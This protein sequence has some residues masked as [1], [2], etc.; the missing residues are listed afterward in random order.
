[1][2]FYS[3]FQYIFFRFLSVLRREDRE[4]MPTVINRVYKGKT[5]CRVYN[6]YIWTEIP[7]TKTI[8]F[9]I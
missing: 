4:T 7:V 6:W 9:S 5:V 3:E 2:S 1:M 8:I